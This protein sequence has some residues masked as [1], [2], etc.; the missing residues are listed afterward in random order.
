M[1]TDAKL[2][3]FEEKFRE[4]KG[5]RMRYF[6]GG[7]GDGTP[8][9]LVHGFGGA[10]SN[11]V[12]LAGAL[13]R[14][15]RVLVPDLP[16]HGGSSALAAT[17]SLAPYADRVALVAEHEGFLP[18]AFAGHSL[19]AVVAVRIA[20]RRPDAVAALVLVAAAGIS[21]GTRR[22][23]WIIKVVALTQP[24]R[25]IAPFAATLARSPL[26]RRLT[27]DGWATADATAL[28]P[29]A[30]E[31]FLAP[32]ALHTDVL[33]AAEALT[34][35]DPRQALARIHCPSL[36]IWGADDPQVPL[37]DAFDYARRLQAPLRVVAGCGHLVIAERPDAC[38]D[39]I[40][41][42]LAL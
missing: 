27:F 2:P 38:L 15:R 17:P 42:F 4:V 10:A 23:K 14:S 34:A 18:A 28:T 39:A 37:G 13:A 19:G 3:G 31:G 24:G 5:V 8:I 20:E 9:V 40:E 6:V 41:S 12:E 26:L 33:G 21:S 29:L 16:G 30:A 25:L 7:A 11:W 36:V 32:P 1:L 22:A 35:E